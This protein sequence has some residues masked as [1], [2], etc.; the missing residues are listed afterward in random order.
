MPITVRGRV[1]VATRTRSR[2]SVLKNPFGTGRSRRAE[3]VIWVWPLA[4]PP[5]LTGVRQVAEFRALSVCILQARRL[6][7]RLIY[8]PTGILA[9]G[10]AGRAIVPQGSR[11][12]VVIHSGG[13]PALPK[14]GRRQSRRPRRWP[15]A[16]HPAPWLRALVR[17]GLER[18]AQVARSAGWIAV[19]PGQ[20]SGWVVGDLLGDLVFLRTL[21]ACCGP[22]ARSMRFRTQDP[23]GVRRL[24]RR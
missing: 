8:A 3:R 2:R 15:C 10:Q 22:A 9:R 4:W 11:R 14:P 17:E 23:G 19:N 21:H 13:K 16:D 1:A 20:V 6:C 5:R 24:L 12:S 18:C 7:G